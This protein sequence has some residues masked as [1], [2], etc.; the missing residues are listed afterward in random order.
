MKA[1]KWMVG[2]KG[3]TRQDSTHFVNAFRVIAQKDCSRLLEG[4]RCAARQIP[5]LALQ[6]AHLPNSVSRS[7]LSHGGIQGRICAGCCAVKVAALQLL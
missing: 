2:V 3:G 1:L 6:A 7:R 5:Q 4:Q